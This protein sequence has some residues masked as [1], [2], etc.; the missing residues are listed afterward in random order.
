MMTAEAESTLPLLSARKPPCSNRPARASTVLRR[1]SCSLTE[2]PKRPWILLA[3]LR[4]LAVSGCSVPSMLSGNPTITSSGCHSLSRRSMRF[5]SGVPSLAFRAVS[6]RAVPVMRCPTA[7]P[8][9]LVPKSKA[10]SVPLIRRAPLRQ[11][12][13][14]YQCQST[15]PRRASDR[16]SAF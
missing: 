14:G 7:T 2:T 13:S 5:Q 15:S 9:L 10:R 6:G 12:W 3:N 8:M 16:Q 4:A 1:S 11:A